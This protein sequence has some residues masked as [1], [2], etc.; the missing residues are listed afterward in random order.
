MKKVKVGIVGTGFIGPVHIEALRRLNNVEVIAL[1]EVNQEI[2]EKKARE[3]GIEKAY[4]DYK[5]LLSD[6]EVD[7]IHICV[8]NHF[9]YLI[10]KEAIL[11][12]KH[13]VCEKPLAMNTDEGRELVD[14]ANKS[15]LICAVNLNCRTY[16]LIQQVKEMIKRGDL[17]TIFAVNGSY[18]QD[19]LFKE[20]DYNWRLQKEFSGESRAIADIGTHWFD[21]IEEVT[22]I[23]VSK[24]C[25]DFATFYK[26]RKRPLKPVETYSGKVLEPR[27]YEDISIDTEDYA[28]VL[29]HMDNNARGS[30]T[31]N[32][33]AA[34]RKNRLYFEIYGSKC[35]VAFDSES[36]NQLWIGNRDRNNEIMIKDPSLM[37]SQAV[38]C[39]AYPGGHTEGFAD[40]TKFTMMRIYHDIVNG[41]P[42]E[43]NYADFE[44]GL[45]ELEIVDAIICSAKEERWISI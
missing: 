35:S 44:D 45:R 1:S 12:G 26:T 9:H 10:A 43:D 41:K 17:G 30:F 23:K 18:Q 14:L 21:V 16:P 37:Y 7:S 22:G 32:Q 5:A 38:T 33:V 40:T 36:P 13:V 39:N 24:V 8:P 27:D 2:A 25:A 3:L 15:K 42:P 34:G 4:G 28:T 20:T 11:A 6:T 31:A 29:F 19:W